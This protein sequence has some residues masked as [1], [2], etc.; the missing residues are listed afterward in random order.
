MAM[1]TNPN[2]A[3]PENNVRKDGRFGSYR[4][5]RLRR[6]LPSG[7]RPLGDEADADEAENEILSNI[8]QPPLI[9]L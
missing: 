9:F 8:V 6:R 1:N 4:S 7:V 5:W 2:G 3:S